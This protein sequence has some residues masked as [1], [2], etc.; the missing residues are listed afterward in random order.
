MKCPCKGC[1]RRW[2]D[3][4]KTC[5]MEC[6]EYGEWKAYRQKEQDAIRREKY[7]DDATKQIIYKK[8]RH[9]R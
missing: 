1:E 8:R 4:G 6:A 7:L 5:H 3:D 2:S 9:N